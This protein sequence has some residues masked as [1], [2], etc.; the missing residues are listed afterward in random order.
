MPCN[1]RPADEAEHNE[2]SSDYIG[3]SDHCRD[4]GAIVVVLRLAHGCYCRCRII[5]VRSS[6]MTGHRKP[7]LLLCGDSNTHCNEMAR[8]SSGNMLFSLGGDITGSQRGVSFSV[9]V[10]S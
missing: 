2:N 3:D 9:T 5:I 6:C 10:T 8:Q 4:D 1:A 7:V